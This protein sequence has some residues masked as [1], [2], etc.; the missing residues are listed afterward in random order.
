MNDNTQKTLQNSL[1]DRNYLDSE[2]YK[3]VQG[4]FAQVGDIVNNDGTSGEADAGMLLADENFTLNHEANYLLSMVR[5]GKH[6]MNSNFIITFNPLE[7]LN[8]QY[9]VFGRVHEDYTDIIDTLETF[10]GS[11][12]DGTPTET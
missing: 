7:Y 1:K 6:R 11:T 5:T 12:L 3:I 4:F 10:S 8:G 2:F 9:T